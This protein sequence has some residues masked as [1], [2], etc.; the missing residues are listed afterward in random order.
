VKRPPAVPRHRS[1]V[2]LRV[3]GIA[4]IACAGAL[5]ACGSDSDSDAE[6]SQEIFC[7]AGQS[8][9]NS[10]AG[11]AD[12]DIVSGGT[13]AVTEQFS[14]IQDDVTELR[15][16]GADVASEEID[17]LGTAV[18]DVESALSDLGDDISISG[19]STVG[20]AIVNLVSAAGA[21]IERLDDA[22]P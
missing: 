12:I 18:D 6:S 1:R 4:S 2:A 22:C 16:S 8:L 10:V 5:T 9:R 13:D 15:E 19:A 11:I 14:A 7:E 20:D 21:L 3:L 17:A